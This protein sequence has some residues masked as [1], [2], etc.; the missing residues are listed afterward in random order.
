MRILELIPTL[1][2]GGAER[3]VA[4]LARQL[5]VLGHQVE[6]A[7][8]G[9]E[10][11][12]ALQQQLE[13][14]DIKLHFLGKGPGLDPKVIPRLGGLLAGRQP[15]LVHTHLHVLKYLLPARVL[16]RQPPFLQ[17]GPLSLPI[18][19]TLHN[20]AQHEAVA[21]DRA[22]QRL[23]FRRAV[24]PVAIGDAVADSVQQVYG[25]RPAEII[26]NGVDVAAHVAPPG[27]RARLRAELGLAEHTP[28]LL[29]VGRLNPQKD[30]RSL[31]DALADPRLAG[32]GAHLLVAGDGELRDDLL[33]RAA[34]LGLTG[35]VH[36]LGLRQDVP[37]LL[38]AADLF[39]LSSRYEGNPL[40]VMEALA[41]GR[42]VVA[43]AVGC[44]PELV[45]DSCG[46]LVAPGDPAALA[47][48]VA[49]LAADPALARRL[50]EAGGR[51]ARDR[52]DLPVMAAAYAQLF[53][54]LLAGRG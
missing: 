46:R 25:F 39:V 47:S 26:P 48:A 28:V 5:Q 32:L 11:G 27:S 52:F 35:R 9:P 13:A 42:A 23:A 51:R 16:R 40:V 19:H 7:V 21:T 36:F 38:A 4:M 54:R 31:L 24:V 53:T 3:I 43:T 45:D 30:H 10:R 37:A 2:T 44:V 17:R 14:A 33:A 6:V 22:V 15:Q 20:L 8:L 41:A 12:S 49:E 34:D 18:V 29:A 50:G 1:D